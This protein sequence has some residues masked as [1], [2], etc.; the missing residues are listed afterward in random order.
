MPGSF[1]WMLDTVD[2]TPLGVVLWLPAWRPFSWQGTGDGVSPA[3][4]EEAD[5]SLGLQ[6]A[7]SWRPSLEPGVRPARVPSA[8]RRVWPASPQRRDALQVNGSGGELVPDVVSRL[9]S[10]FPVLIYAL[11][12]LAEW[13]ALNPN[14]F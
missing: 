12:A 2:V 6:V 4:T 14:L 7:P 1:G 13:A 8:G 3:T 10:F 9:S 11:Q 5:L